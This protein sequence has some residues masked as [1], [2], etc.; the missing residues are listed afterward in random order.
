MR[1]FTWLPLLF[2]STRI[3]LGCRVCAFGLVSQTQAP[4]ILVVSALHHGLETLLTQH[5]GPL[6]APAV[7]KREVRT[8]ETPTVGRQAGYSCLL[9]SV[10]KVTLSVVSG[11]ALILLSTVEA[12]F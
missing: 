6:G 4:A 7:G 5:P 10:P 1:K 2:L 12:S 8:Q 11:R 9:M 3:P